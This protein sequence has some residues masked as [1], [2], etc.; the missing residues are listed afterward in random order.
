[1]ALNVGQMVSELRRM[2]VTELRRKY[3]EVFGEQ[4][5]SGHK[6]Y[7]V[8]RIAWRIQADA[9]GGLSERARRRA[10]EIATDAGCAL[11]ARPA[12]PP[13]GSGQRTNPW[14]LTASM[15]RPTS[16]CPCPGLC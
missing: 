10:L 11:P 3:A 15:S 5:R 4:T 13:R 2:S 9:E 7:L 16:G 6:D 12:H 1:M 14:R 8:R